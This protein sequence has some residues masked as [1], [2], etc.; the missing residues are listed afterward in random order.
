GGAVG[1]RRSG[2][3]WVG[4]GNPAWPDRS[5]WAG[6]R[7]VR[8]SHRVPHRQVRSGTSSPD[9]PPLVPERTASKLVLGSFGETAPT[10]ADALRLDPDTR[11]PH[12]LRLAPRSLGSFGGRVL[13]RARWL[14]AQTGLGYA[15]G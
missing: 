8:G 14:G 7:F 13:G 4:S 10:S 1:E 2:G 5:P 11:E 6:A 15:Q 3:G 9:R 12:W